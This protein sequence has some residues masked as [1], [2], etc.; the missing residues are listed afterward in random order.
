MI[1]YLSERIPFSVSLLLHLQL[2]TN[3]SERY[4]KEADTGYRSS[5]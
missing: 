2:R 3:L 4:S 5:R 1:S